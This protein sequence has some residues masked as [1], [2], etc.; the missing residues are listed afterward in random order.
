[1]AK[2]TK[3]PGTIGAGI[4]NAAEKPKETV[5]EMPT[6]ALPGPGSVVTEGP[7]HEDHEGV[8]KGAEEEQAKSGQVKTIQDAG[9]FSL[10]EVTRRVADAAEKAMK[11]W[12]PV[13]HAAINAVHV[14]LGDLHV[15]VLAGKDHLMKYLKI[16]D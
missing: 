16:E 1:M 5:K 10:A 8:T 7:G 4:V 3:G 6:G 12:D 2:A 14:S 13:A 15:R 9:F 11:A